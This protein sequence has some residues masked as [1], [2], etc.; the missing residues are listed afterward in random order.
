LEGRVR[1]REEFTQSA[2]RSERRRTPRREKQDPRCKTGTWG[3]DK[4]K[5]KKAA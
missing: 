5:K 3:T 1:R 4:E 2:Q